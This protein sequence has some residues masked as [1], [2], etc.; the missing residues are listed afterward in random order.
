[1]PVNWGRGVEEAVLT[2]NGGSGDVSVNFGDERHT[3]VI[4]GGQ[5]A[6]CGP[7]GN[8]SERSWVAGSREN[9]IAEWG[10]STAPFRSMRRGPRGP[11]MVWCVARQRGR[12]G[13]SGSATRGG[14][15]GGS[16]RPGTDGGR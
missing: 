2:E 11:D 6:K 3:P 13:G 15:S 1:V 5:E 16:H 9:E 8:G 12:G 4:G 7:R 10:C 14:G